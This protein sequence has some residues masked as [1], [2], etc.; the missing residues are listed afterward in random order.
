MS[1]RAKE[2]RRYGV[3]GWRTL[4][5]NFDELTGP[6]VFQSGQRRA[7]NWCQV[8]DLIGFRA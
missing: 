8:F 4:T 3:D 1:D 2:L 7:Q 5:A 6:D